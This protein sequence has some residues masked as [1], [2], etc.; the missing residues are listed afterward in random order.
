ML[1]RSAESL[2]RILG[3]NGLSC[4]V[5]F[6]LP[7]EEVLNR[8]SKRASKEGRVDDSKHTQF[9]RIRIYKDQ[10]EPLVNYYQTKGKLLVVNALGDVGQVA[11]SLEEAILSLPI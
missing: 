10:T 5:Y 8:M 6:E 7:E 2:N 1:F 9:E 4:A 3:V 11:K